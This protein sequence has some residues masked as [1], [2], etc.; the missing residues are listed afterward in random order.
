MSD[1]DPINIDLTP[2]HCDEATD[3]KTPSGAG[4]LELV[5]GA[6]EDEELN[7]N[8]GERVGFLCGVQVQLLETSQQMA[9][10]PASRRRLLLLFGAVGGGATALATNDSGP[11]LGGRGILDGALLRQ[12]VQ[13]AVVPLL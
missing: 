10:T 6:A 9:T 3:G 4:S 11:R 13:L 5:S 7:V 8:Q 1:Q 12:Q 2:S